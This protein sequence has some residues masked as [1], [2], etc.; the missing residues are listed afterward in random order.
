L[1]LV[2]RQQTGSLVGALMVLAG[3][4]LLALLTFAALS[5]FIVLCDRI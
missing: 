5:G 1:H 3:M 4:V 2:V